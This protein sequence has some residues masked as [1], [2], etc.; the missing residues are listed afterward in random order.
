[1]N[2]IRLAITRPI[3]VV[4]A[5]VMVVMF[6][7]VALTTIP[8]QLAPD[9]RKPV[10]TVETYWPGAAP[11]EVEREVT[12]QQEEALKGLTGL[13]QMISQSQDGKA[14]IELTFRV[15]QDMGRAL[16]L[17]ANRLDRV[18]D[19]P[20]EAQQPT[21]STSGNEDSAIAWFILQP[22]EGNER[23]IH[24]YG[25]F[26]EDAIRSRIERVPGIAKVN[27]YGGGARE[28]RVVVDPERLARFQLTVPRVVEALRRANAKFQRR[29]EAIEDALAR[30]GKTPGDSTLEEMDALWDAAKMMEKG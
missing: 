21:L 28:M 7:A 18:S 20:D 24:T 14:E 13:E 1:M 5:V 17:T 2:L 9:V 6:G 15:G 12:N 10:I 26:A 8:I 22:A 23:A 4:A 25:T 27:V 3:A 29:F 11:A 30:T 16:L 19:Y